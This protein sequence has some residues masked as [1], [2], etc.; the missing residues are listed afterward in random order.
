RF[1]TDAPLRSG[2]AWGQRYLKDGVA[3]AEAD[4]GRG[5]LFLFGP[6]ILFRGQ[7]HGTFKLFFNGFHLARSEPVRLP[8]GAVGAN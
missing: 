7:P 5:K 6:E 4:V 2:W 3:M 8:G 1:T